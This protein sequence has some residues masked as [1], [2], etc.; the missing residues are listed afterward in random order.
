MSESFLIN[1][2]NLSNISCLNVFFGCKN[3]KCHHELKFSAENM[4]EQ[5]MKLKAV[6]DKTVVHNFE[7]LK[8][9]T[10]ASWSSG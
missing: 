1:S 6:Q 8:K 7:W 10:F 4:A 3:R 9:T 5:K 2:Q